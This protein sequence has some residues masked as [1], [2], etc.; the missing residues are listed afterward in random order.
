MEV[1]C[2]IVAQEKEKFIQH[3]YGVLAAE[4]PR[5]DMHQPFDPREV[6]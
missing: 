4:I 6:A 5:I 2:D 3:C 1:I